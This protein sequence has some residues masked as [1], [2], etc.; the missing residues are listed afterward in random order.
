MFDK[1]IVSEPEGADFKNRRS[2]FMVS[3]LVVGILFLTAV[4]FSIFAADYGLGNG[5]FELVEMVMPP[6]MAAAVEP[7]PQPRNND[8]QSTSSEKPSREVNMSRPDE[9]TIVPTGIS[10]SPNKYV[11]RPYGDFL[12]RDNTGPTVPGIGSRDP[13]N[14]PSTG[15]LSTVQTPSE[16]TSDVEPPPISKPKPRAPVSKGVLNGEAKS[17]PK[18]IY[19][20]AARAVRAQGQVTVQVT[21]DESGRVVSANAVNGHLLLRQE[22]E[23]AA[24][25]ARFSPTLLSDV[26]VKVTGVITYNFV[27]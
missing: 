3:S 6:E 13:G 11:P 26:P 22:A 15:G 8:P 4:V 27:L 24:R 14:G 12:I 1:L 17:L 23:R 9:P 5:G 16:D 20:A 7:E 21:I 2:Y 19:S 10:T 25:N 18:P